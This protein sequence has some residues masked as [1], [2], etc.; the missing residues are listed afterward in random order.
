M[1]E[2]RPPFEAVSFS[3]YSCSLSPSVYVVYYSVSA[4]ADCSN[5]GNTYASVTISYEQN[6]LRTRP[7][8]GGPIKAFN[9]AD[10]Y[11]NCTTQ[12]QCFLSMAESAYNDCLTKSEQ[13]QDH[14]YPRLE[15]PYKVR[16]LNPQWANC[17]SVSEDR[18][19]A[20]FDPPRAL[21]SA[22]AMAPKPTR[23]PIISLSAAPAS[24]I[25]PAWPSATNS[26]GDA[27]PPRPSD[28][29]VADPSDP[30]PDQNQHGD[31]PASK[32]PPDSPAQE[33]GSGSPLVSKPQAPSNGK[34]TSPQD[35]SN[36]QGTDPPTQDDPGSGSKG[37]NEQ[38]GNN[39]GPNDLSYDPQP[40]VDPSPSVDSGPTPTIQW[41]G[42]TI[43]PGKSSQYT[44]PNIGVLTAGGPAV[45]TNG[46]EYS[47][48][49]SATAILSNGHK[50]DLA[51]VAASQPAQAP[52]LTFA[53]STYTA[54]QASKFVIAGQ[55][56]NPGHSIS[57][58]GT[59]IFLSPD[60][61]VAVIGSNS[62]KQTLVQPVPS[63]Y[64][65]QL[66]LTG[67]VYTADP[68]GNFLIAG[69]TLT[70]GGVITAFNTPISLAPGGTV[71]VVG[72]ETQLINPPVV[73][74]A[75]VL[76]FNGATFT[77]DSRGRFIIAGQTL[78][79]GGAI[80][81]SGTPISV[82][83]GDSVA[84]VGVTSQLLISGPAITQAPVFTFDN[85][86]YTADASSEFTIEGQTLTR[87]GRITVDGATLLF[88]AG[89]A[90]VV[91]GTST[92]VLGVA[93]FTG[94]EASTI[95]FT[96]QTYTEDTSQ[97]F[98][99]GGQT[100]KKGGVITVNGTPLSFAAG[101]TDVVV[102]SSSTE[103]VGLGGWVM[104]GFGNGA[105]TQTSVVAFEGEAATR[106]PGILI[107]IVGIVV[108]VG[109]CI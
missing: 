16:A 32:N 93:T 17:E 77:A 89:G 94:A 15:Y 35:P 56:L 41:A 21:V 52:V 10:L 13:M 31:A 2:L 98:V 29:A 27:S 97:G 72:S 64:T 74:T 48:A 78:T 14:C 33:S 45:T 42:S 7:A 68:F 108:A 58:S 25:L 50:A 12:T 20:V 6:E 19:W 63:P 49:P 66:T 18:D 24:S 5:I 43:Q 84:V 80:T 95:T 44:I 54:N 92:Q 59:P 81:V 46:V 23:D 106:R 100:L 53:G 105:S 37:S 101:G 4:T 62:N 38:G 86:I 28:P 90:N 8:T 76:T 39:Q 73:T 36:Y 85:T 67:S 65:P 102:G 22:N 99:I 107:G 96:G 109:F 83:P 71:A 40:P 75:P 9:F 57:P 82:I 69:K 55:T 51:P 30:P 88:D 60:G 3:L 104:S 26:P 79:P 34:D 87:G 1:S 47:L 70:P 103:A 91:V 61:T 11:S